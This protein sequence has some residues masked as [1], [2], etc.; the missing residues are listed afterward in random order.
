MVKYI[1]I[2]ISTEALQNSEVFKNYSLCIENEVP[3][4]SLQ[5][6]CYQKWSE[7]VNVQWF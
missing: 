3:A 1:I 7:G 5:P 2:N 6:S 4:A